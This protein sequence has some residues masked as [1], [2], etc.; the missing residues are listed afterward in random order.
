MSFRE[1]HQN[2]PHIHIY[3][4]PRLINR[5]RL[6]SS[7]IYFVECEICGKLKIKDGGRQ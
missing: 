5:I 3:S 6:G 7:W 2:T 4:L 1:K